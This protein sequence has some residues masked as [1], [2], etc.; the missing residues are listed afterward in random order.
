MKILKK[1]GALLLVLIMTIGTVACGEEESVTYSEMNYM[2][3]DLTP[4]VTLGQYKGLTLAADPIVVTDA[5]VES[6]VQNLIA[7]N[8]KYEEYEEPVTDRLTEAGDYLLIDFT[9]FMEGEQFEGGTAEGANVLLAEDNG[10]IDWFED[11]LYGVMPGTVVETTNFF[12][13]N[14]YEEFAGRE[15]T[16]KITVHSIVGHYTVPELTDEFVKSIT[17]C[18][19][20]DAYRELVRAALL[21]NATAS[22]NQTRYQ[23]LWNAVLANATIHSLPEQQ[24]MFYYTY[25]RSYYESVAE[26]YGYTYEEYLEACGA[27]DADVM[28]MVEDAVREEIVFYSIVKAENIAI[29]EEEYTEAAEGYA[30]VEGVTLEELEAAYGYDYIAESVLWDKVIYTLFDTTTFI[31][32]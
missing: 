29:T 25:D 27:T 3:T 7:N 26:Q 31:S 9:G 14:Y 15:V 18:E 10:Y 12:P 6:M 5:D 16:F 32:E 19:T 2:T 21:E 20:V 17:G 4:Y 24:V 30:E 28:K 13:E 23:I 22:A 8:S 11:D 1:I